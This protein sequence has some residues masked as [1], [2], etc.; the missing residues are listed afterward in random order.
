EVGEEQEERGRVGAA[1]D[2]DEERSGPQDLVRADV[3]PD[4]AAD[5]GWDHR[6]L[7]ADS[8]RRPRGY[9]SR[10]LTT[11]LSSLVARAIVGGSAPVAAARSFDG[12]R[13]FALP[14]RVDARDAPPDA[15][16]ASAA[17][18]AAPCRGFAASSRG[19]RR[20][21][22]RDPCRARRTSSRQARPWQ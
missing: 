13:G 20:D 8:D 5:R 1:G 18:R 19:H 14:R 3:V 7:G 11:E 17:S 4:S 2:R 22:Y 16:R 9:E 21:A 15:L 6:W 12:S 10:A